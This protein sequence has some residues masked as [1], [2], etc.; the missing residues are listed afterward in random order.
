MR[1]AAA[2]AVFCW[3]TGATLNHPGRLLAVFAT[4]DKN[5]YELAL[6]SLRQSLTNW[7]NRYNMTVRGLD[8]PQ[9]HEMS[10]TRNAVRTSKRPMRGMEMQ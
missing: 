6:G 10:G 8:R 3:I 9:A 2:H 1:I 7:N 5:R 4:F